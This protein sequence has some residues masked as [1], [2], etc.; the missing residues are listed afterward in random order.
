MAEQMSLNGILSNEEPKPKEPTNAEPQ[1]VKTSPESEAEVDFGKSAKQEHREKEYVAQGRDRETGQYV[2]K[3]SE[4]K[5]ATPKEPEKPKEPPKIELTD[6]EKALLA[7]ANTET[8][9]RQELERRV[10]GYE[11]EKRQAVAQPQ[12]PVAETQQPTAFWDDPDAAIQRFAQGIMHEITR[13]KLQTAEAIARTRHTDFDEK[14]KIFGELLKSTPGLY[15]D[16]IAAP[17]MA[18]F[19]YVVSKQRMELREAGDL[20]DYRKKIEKET[21]IQVRKEIEAEIAKKD[22]EKQKLAESLPRTLSD[23]RGI[24][25]QTPVWGGPTPLSSILKH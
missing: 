15:Q 16:W 13:T 25:Q 5:E 11:A 1:I 4:K 7:R 22:S 21:A 23:V 19:A 2:Q 12:Q 8:I 24:S 9:K 14:T 18:E 17:D 6:K 10:A 20:Q 3:E